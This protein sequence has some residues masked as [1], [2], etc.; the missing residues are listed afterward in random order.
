[1]L[2]F[3]LVSIILAV[4]CL[5]LAGM[6]FQ[7]SRGN[8]T[9]VAPSWPRKPIAPGVVVGAACLVWSAYYGCLMLE[10]NLAK[11]HSIVWALVPITIALS[12]FYLDYL[13]SRAFGGFFTLS[14]NFLIIKAFVHDVPGRPFF[15]C[16]CLVLGVFGMVALSLPWRIRDLI[17]LGGKNKTLAQA[18]SA[19]FAFCGIV[20]IIMPLFAR[21]YDL[22]FHSPI[23]L[24]KLFGF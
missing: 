6:F 19:I 5:C 3:L 13:N 24:D 10:G 23:N 14:A 18:L 20:L 12:I 16:I 17:E 11:F 4:F 15:S 8:W 1:M 2:L 9:D 7:L 21:Q 22:E